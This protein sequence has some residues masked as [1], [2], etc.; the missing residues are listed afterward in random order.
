MLASMRVLEHLASMLASMLAPSPELS[1]SQRRLIE[2]RWDW[3][4]CG[5]REWCQDFVNNPNHKL[6]RHLEVCGRDVLRQGRR[7]GRPIW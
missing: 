2:H 6:A 7:P 5:D 3:F 1:A 4:A